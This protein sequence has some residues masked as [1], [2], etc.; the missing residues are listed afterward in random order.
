MPLL[1]RL[2]QQKHRQY[3]L[4]RIT[5]LKLPIE[6]KKDALYKKAASILRV[7][8]KDIL[9]LQ[10]KKK[11]VDARKKPQLFYLYSVDV[12]IKNEEKVV[13][14]LPKDC[15][16]PKDVIY[17][18]PEAD[19]SCF[20]KRPV[21]VGAGPAGLFCAYI[22]A[23]SG[24]KT[25]L[26]ERG[27]A[28][29]ERIK[30]IDTFWK[31][32]VLSEESNVQFGEGGAGTFSDGK[33]NTLVKDKTGKNNFVL[34]TFV[35]FGAPEHILYDAKPHIGTDVLQKVIVNM[36]HFLQDNGVE[37]RFRTKMTDLHI[38]QGNVVGISLNN[39]EYFETNRV[40]LCIGH[41]ARDTFEMLYD[42]KV[43]MEAKP[44]AIGFRIEHPRSF[45]DASQYGEEN[46]SKLPAANYK[47]TAQT[48]S[49]RGVY[50][51]CMCP[52]G[53]VVNA[54][55]EPGRLAVNGM[56]YSGRDGKNSNSAMI[57]TITPDDFDKNHPLSGMEYQR[58]LERRSY[59]LAGGKVPVETYG[60]FKKAV[61]E[62]YEPV[63]SEDPSFDDSFEPQIKGAYAFAPVHDILPQNLN[64]DLIDGIEQFG[65]KIK[66]FNADEA[67]LSGIESRTS[68][69]VK[70][71]RDETGN[72][73]LVKGLYPCGEGAGYA[74]GIM[75][76]AMDGMNIAEKILCASKQ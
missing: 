61:L 17:K 18:V 76:A 51:F 45:I 57:V 1:E 56:S 68:S 6:H 25:I 65:R 40:V 52:G 20:E 48:A 29:E 26:I 69:P 44:F 24:I 35:K 50:S 28:V 47:L 59:E 41:S 53:Y 62:N 63:K 13:K 2:L 64:V 55:S 34:E 4:I 3:K 15:V 32:G 70:I 7:P 10:I 58:K 33:L 27:D 8:E 23:L 39:G 5:Q 60:D 22:F 36:R 46:V 16:I 43:S 73:L 38:D 49:G 54:S 11:S 31:N 9:S 67:F 21:I 12:Q 37:V 14:K 72:S 30:A 71:V 42:K 19:S 66:G 75:S 74:G